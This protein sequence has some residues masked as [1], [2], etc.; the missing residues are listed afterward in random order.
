MEPGEIQI[1]A[2]AGQTVNSQ[3][4]RVSVLAPPTP[5]FTPETPAPTA[6]PAP[7]PT[8]TP[9]PSPTTP[10][11]PTPPAI[12][13]E[14]Q[15]PDTTTSLPAN[16]RPLNSIDLL[17]ALGATLLA[18]LLGF[19]LGQQSRKSL[20]RRVRLAL[21]TLIGGLLAYLIY[22][23]G[24]LRPEQWLF[25]QPDGLAG[26]LTVA[27]LAFVFGLTALG[28]SGQADRGRLTAD[29]RRGP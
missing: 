6:T 28:L 1:F 24:W 26:H 17:S 12:G 11:S 10:P 7:P 5:T 21:W 15:P 16:S 25:D 3:K 14:P 29:R 13:D 27:S 9:V 20:S 2:V 18:G 8:S 23:A 22:G 4:I 19:W